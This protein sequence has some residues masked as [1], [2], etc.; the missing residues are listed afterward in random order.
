[1]YL[2][3]WTG[4]YDTYSVFG[5]LLMVLLLPISVIIGFIALRIWLIQQNKVE[6]FIIYKNSSDTNEHYKG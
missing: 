4:E 1:M 6:E 2:E 5:F 3:Q